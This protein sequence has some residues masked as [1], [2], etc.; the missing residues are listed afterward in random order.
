MAHAFP[1]AVAVV[2][3]NRQIYVYYLLSS[4]EDAMGVW[5]GLGIR[6]IEKLK[7]SR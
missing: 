4:Q 3:A 1:A 5:R 6:A 2:V 7:T